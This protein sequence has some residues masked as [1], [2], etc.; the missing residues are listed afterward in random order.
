MCRDAGGRHIVGFL[1]GLDLCDGRYDT[2]E[3][4]LFSSLHTYHSEDL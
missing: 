4:A 1:G 2:G 3:H